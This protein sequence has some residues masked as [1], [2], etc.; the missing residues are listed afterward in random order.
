MLTDEE[1]IQI[2]AAL[3]NK[4]TDHHTAAQYAER[5]S[6]QWQGL[7]R[8][9][10]ENH[11]LP[12][13]AKNLARHDLTGLLPDAEKEIILKTPHAT[14]AHNLLLLHSA[15]NI[16]T[17]AAAINVDILP[18]KGITFIDRLYQPDERRLS[19]MDFLVRLPQIGDI[20]R[21]ALR[22]GF[23]KD[24]GNL[25]QEF[26][27][28]ESG[29]IKYSAMRSGVRVDAEFHWDPSPG[30]ALK[31]AFS[32]DA[33]TLWNLSSKKDGRFC[34]STEGEI[35]FH[36]FHLAARHSFSRL[37]WFVDLHRMITTAQPDWDTLT[38]LLDSAGLTNAAGC[39]F[40]FMERFLATGFTYPVRQHF[41]LDSSKTRLADRI[42]IN[43]MAGKTRLKQSN[44]ATL[45]ISHKKASYIFRLLFPPPDFI[46]QRYPRIP[47]PFQ[48]IYRPVDLTSKII[49]KRK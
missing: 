42:V 30:P 9:A 45:L 44:I 38:R 4:D 3:A 35:L 19:D 27:I 33:D 32:F 11:V 21:L 5:A 25:P 48:Y 8:L 7:H 34:L 24:P 26:S 46:R 6:L 49:K 39:V 41:D 40:R 47:Y 20:E 10:E 18:L 23:R 31:K 28:R 1:K 13:I 17:S 15:H 16:L 12:T 22:A 36:I 2:L 29:E 14:A 37:M 43:S